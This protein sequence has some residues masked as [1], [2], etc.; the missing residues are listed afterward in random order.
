L[1]E[2][3]RAEF[4]KDSAKSH[5]AKAESMLEVVGLPRAA[6]AKYPHEFSGGQ[7]RLGRPGDDPEPGLVIADEPVAP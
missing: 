1:S 7:Q 2:A 5:L 4:G 3:D 6:L